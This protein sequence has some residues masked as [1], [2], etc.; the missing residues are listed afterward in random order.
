MMS[1]VINIQ[2]DI[3]EPELESVLLL[4]DMASS[5]YVIIA[6]VAYILQCTICDLSFIF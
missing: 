4:K 2:V 6:I 1:P 5:N 3:G